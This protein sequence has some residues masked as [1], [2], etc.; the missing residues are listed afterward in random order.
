MGLEQ[1]VG[2]WSVC[3]RYKNQALAEHVATLLVAS[4]QALVAVISDAVADR[5]S[6]TRLLEIAAG[7]WQHA[8]SRQRSTHPSTT[9]SE[10]RHSVCLNLTDLILQLVMRL[11]ELL[12]D[13]LVV[14]SADCPAGWMGSSK[15]LGSFTLPS[16]LDSWS[17][18]V[19]RPVH[20]M[21]EQQRSTRGPLSSLMQQEEAAMGLGASSGA[22]GFE[23]QQRGSGQEGTAQQDLSP[24]SDNHQAGPA[25]RCARQLALLVPQTSW[26][27]IN[28]AA[29]KLR[30]S[31]F[32]SHRVHPSPSTS[33][34]C[35]PQPCQWVQRAAQG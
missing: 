13:P 26:E 11:W 32:T 29:A 17:Y 4:L 15:Y 9:D 7:S 10:P 12:A 2:G 28:A 3:C 27:D 24:V 33:P 18:H 25:A 23:S 22:A 16:Y 31:P 5:Y 20:L 19:T 1:W 14:G 8:K 21:V 6:R 30:S 34:P 35:I